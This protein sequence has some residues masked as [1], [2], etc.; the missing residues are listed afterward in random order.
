M[1]GYD[2]EITYDLI[3]QQVFIFKRVKQSSTVPKKN[4]HSSLLDAERRT[5]GPSIDAAF[6]IPFLN[7]TE[8]F[9]VEVSGAP[10]KDEFEHFIGDGNKIAKNLKIMI[11]HIISLRTDWTVYKLLH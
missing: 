4:E 6:V 10:A 8:F 7:N 3:S 5:P 9:I 2:I 1:V 11:K